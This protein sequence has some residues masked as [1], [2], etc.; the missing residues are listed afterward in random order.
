[1][2]IID[3]HISIKKT[4][5]DAIARAVAV[6]G[7]VAIALIHVLQLPAAFDAI[8]YLGALFIGAVVGSLLLAAILTRTSD[9]LA[10]TATGGLAAVILLCYVV[11]RSV[12][13]PGFT[14]DVGEWAEAPGLASMV[15]EGLL[16]FLTTAVLLTR[17]HPMRSLAA[18]STAS[19]GRAAAG[20]RSRPAVG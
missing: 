15:I 2:E 7:L 20:T 14:D 10:W 6:G 3:I 12:G 18:H 5:D 8:G 4:L 1:M 9:G 16:V 11:S 17:E 13:L 19:T